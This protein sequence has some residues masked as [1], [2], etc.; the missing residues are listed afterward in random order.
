[1]IAQDTTDVENLCGGTHQVIVTDAVGCT[2]VTDIVIGAGA[3]IEANLS[4]LGETC[5]G[6]CDG[7]ASVAPTGGTGSGYAFLWGPGDPVGQGTSEVS[8]LCAGWWNVTIADDAGCDTVITFEILPFQPIMPTAT[9]QEVTCHGACDGS[10]SLNTTGGVGAL[11]FQWTP[12]PGSGQGTSLVGGLCAGDW[13]VV[14]TDAANCDTSVTITI[15]EPVELTVAV[16]SVAQASCSSAS[17]GAVSITASGG[18]PGHTFSW[19]GPNGFQSTA[20]DLAG[21]L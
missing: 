20:E 10:I 14:I 12:E 18:T 13:T 5:H 9:V 8:G 4:F 3:P 1:M 11:S 7:T 21:I 19:T 17:D 2:M 16:D 15:N 6:P